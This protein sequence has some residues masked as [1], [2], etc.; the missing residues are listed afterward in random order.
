MV[1]ECEL[2]DAQV[3]HARRQVVDLRERVRSHGGEIGEPSSNGV[4]QLR[5][6]FRPDERRSSGMS[7]SCPSKSF[8]RAMAARP[9]ARS[10]ENDC[11]AGQ[12]A[13]SE[14]SNQH[15]HAGIR[16]PWPLRTSSSSDN[17]PGAS[18]T[19]EGVDW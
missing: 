2:D 8:S 19:T 1:V 13:Q 15:T 10:D 9:S 12:S 3:R 4:V 16:A 7:A 18:N 14:V 6:R 5:T 11:G 17:A